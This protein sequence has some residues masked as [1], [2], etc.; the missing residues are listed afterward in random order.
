MTAAPAHAPQT[1]ADALRDAAARLAEAGVESPSR[2]ARRLLAAALDVDVAEL[3]GAGAEPL[4]AGVAARFAGMVDAR[5]RRMPV[6]RILGTR[7]FW[8]LPLGLSPATLDPRPDSETLVEAV[9][10]RVADRDAPRRVLDLGTGSGC[11]LLA[12]LRELPGATG[13][14]V[15]RDPAAAATAAAN[16]RSLGL[17]AR[18]AF[19]A[20]DWARALT[21]PFDVVVSNPPYLTTAELAAAEPEVAAWDPAGALDGGPDGL[22][23]YRALLAGLENQV[24]PAG[25]VVLE[26]GADRDGAVADLVADHGLTVRDRA[27]DLTGT[28]RCVIATDARPTGG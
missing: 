11:L 27:R 2:D 25:L 23:A 5:A 19:L 13:I 22:A 14:G 15:D 16:A 6:A 4:P 10:A 9:L 12:L 20:G 24:A 18:T 3:L 17:T 7:E 1:R 21:G 8:S 26:V 28:V